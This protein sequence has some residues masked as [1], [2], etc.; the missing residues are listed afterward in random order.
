MLPLPAA[1]YKY[2]A[3]TPLPQEEVAVEVVGDDVGDDVGEDVGAVVGEA[4]GLVVGDAL[5]LADGLAEGDADGDADG[6]SVGAFVTNVGAGWDEHNA[7]LRLF[8]VFVL[9]VVE[10]ACHLQF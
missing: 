7:A 1:M 10:P 8:L 9:Y 4:L 3:R 5:G 6:D 2:L